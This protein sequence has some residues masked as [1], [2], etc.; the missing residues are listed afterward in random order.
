[1]ESQNLQFGFLTVGCMQLHFLDKW[2]QQESFLKM[3][4]FWDM[5]AFNLVEVDRRFIGSCIIRAIAIM[6]EAVR[7]YE[8]SGYMYETTRRHIPE[9]CHLHST[10]HHLNVKCH[11]GT[12]SL[13]HYV[14]TEGEPHSASYP[15]GT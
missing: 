7:T 3:A 1:M 15:V 12:S 11:L 6:M 2:K 10:S 9:G 14:H 13:R 8:T 4:A 5:D